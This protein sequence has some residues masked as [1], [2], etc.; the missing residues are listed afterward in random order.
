MDAHRVLTPVGASN[1]KGLAD[2]LVPNVSALVVEPRDPIALR[3]AIDRLLADKNLAKTLARQAVEVFEARSV[4]KY[5]AEIED[6][7]ASASTSRTTIPRGS[8]A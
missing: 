6:L 7:V 5:L 2:Y 8:A 4:E 1:V 3:E